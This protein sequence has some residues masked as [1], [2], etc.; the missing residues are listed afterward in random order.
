MLNVL[1]LTAS[2]DSG[3]PFFDALVVNTAVV[4]Y[5]LTNKHNK[6]RTDIN[7]DNFLRNII[8]DKKRLN[9]YMQ[10]ALLC[11]FIWSCDQTLVD[12]T[13]AHQAL[14]HQI[15]ISLGRLPVPA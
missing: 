6:Y 7:A 1:L 11:S 14:R 10:A 5:E 9:A 2:E 15:D 3:V 8:V 13:P 4:A 12:E